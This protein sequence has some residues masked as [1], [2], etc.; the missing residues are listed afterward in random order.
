LEQV[1]RAYRELAKQ[2]H[3]DRG[4]NA[5]QFKRLQALYEQAKR[6]AK[7]STAPSQEP[8]PTAAASDS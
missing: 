5:E 2:V 6:Q 7:R 4:G 3:P 8:R 1:E